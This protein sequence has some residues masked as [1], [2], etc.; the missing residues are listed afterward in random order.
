[1]RRNNSA[2]VRTPCSSFILYSAR[3]HRCCR[4]LKSPDWCLA[5]ACPA[6]LSSGPAA[7]PRV[8]VLFEIL[9]PSPPR[10]ARA[11][12]L[13][14]HGGHGR[15]ERAVDR[16]PAPSRDPGGSAQAKPA[17]RRIH[18]SARAAAAAVRA[19]AALQASVAL[20]IRACYTQPWFLGWTHSSD[21]QQVWKAAIFR[22]RVQFGW[23]VGSTVGCAT[24]N[25]TD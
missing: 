22:L 11:L 17:L 16:G 13:H 15:R 3:T 25:L 2:R 7:C 10:P 4:A 14:R 6:P 24:G 8:R 21:M 23:G 18:H 12:L 19:A 1:M 9:R 20:R 5:S